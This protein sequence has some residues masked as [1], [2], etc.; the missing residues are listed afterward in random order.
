MSKIKE[1]GALEPENKGGR[2]TALKGRDLAVREAIRSHIHRFQRVESHYCRSSS[3]K[4]YLHPDLRLLKMVEMFNSLNKD[5]GTTT[6]YYTYSNEFHQMNLGFHHPRKDQCTLCNTYRRG[7]QKQKADLESRYQAHINEKNTVRQI[8]GYVKENL[9]D[10]TCVA[11]CFDLQQIIHL[12]IAA[13]SKLFYHIRLTNFNLT[14]YDIR[15]KARAKEDLQRFQR[16]FFD[17]FAISIA[18]I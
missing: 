2:P 17:I 16:A 1:S 15:T 9:V 11:A 10:E 5:K 4:E 8:K 14:A 7:D 3:K 12:P 6:S 18:R 13:D